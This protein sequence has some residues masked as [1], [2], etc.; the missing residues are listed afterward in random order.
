MLPKCFCIE[1]AEYF[2]KLEDKQG[3]LKK[4]NILEKGSPNCLAE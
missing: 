4:T 1:N 2:V 3:T